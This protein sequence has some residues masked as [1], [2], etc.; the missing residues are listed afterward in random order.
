[1]P[2]INCNDN[3]RVLCIRDREGEG[4]AN[5]KSYAC[6]GLWRAR[7][8][9]CLFASQNARGWSV[10]S[11]VHA[12]RHLRSTA[13]YQLPGTALADTI[14]RLIPKQLSI[15][16]LAGDAIYGSNTSAGL[17]QASP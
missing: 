16:E 14:C 7:Q 13:T 8:M 6:N 4:R 1:M 2:T 9:A 3:A 10:H 11:E 17:V 15:S 12:A 5:I